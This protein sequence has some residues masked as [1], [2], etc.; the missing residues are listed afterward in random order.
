MFALTK[1]SF[2]TLVVEGNMVSSVSMAIV[3]IALV[4]LAQSRFWQPF[5]CRYQRLSVKCKSMLMAVCGV[6]FEKE[7]KKTE[8]WLCT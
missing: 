2:A 3:N 5:L 4:D 1:R 8:K 7:I 6:K